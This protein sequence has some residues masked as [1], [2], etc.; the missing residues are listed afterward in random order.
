MDLHEFPLIKE[1]VDFL[2][3]NAKKQADPDVGHDKV[4]ALEGLELAM[5]ELQK[6]HDWI[7][8]NVV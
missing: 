3:N 1:H 4:G 5:A 8:A 6:A 7:T 2:A